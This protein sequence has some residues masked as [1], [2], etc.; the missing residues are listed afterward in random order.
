MIYECK[1]SSFQTTLLLFI[2]YSSNN[3]NLQMVLL[4][5]NYLNNDTLTQMYFHGSMI[6]NFELLE[7]IILLEFLNIC[8]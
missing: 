3:S 5:E 1:N 4:T 7:K 8:C 6:I 2:S